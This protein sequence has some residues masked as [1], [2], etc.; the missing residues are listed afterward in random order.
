[1]LASTSTKKAATASVATETTPSPLIR[2]SDATSSDWPA[3]LIGGL[4]LLT[5]A[6]LRG[7]ANG[8]GSPGILAT[9]AG[10]V[11]LLGGFLAIERHSNAPM[12][13]LSLFRQRR[14][15]GAQ[16]VVFGI[17]ASF[18]AVFFYM[19]L[20]LQGVLGLSPIQTGLVYLPGT[21][22][23]F[24]VSALTAQF[25]S[26]VRPAKLAVGGLALVAGGMLSMLLTTTSSSW[27]AILLGE[28]ICCLGTGIFNPAGS[29]LALDA[30]PKHQSGLAAGAN[31]TFRQAGIA[32]GIAALGTLV[33]ADAALGGN[34]AAYVAGFHHI[35]IAATLIATVCATATAALL[36]STP[37]WIRG[38][39]PQTSN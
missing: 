39:A 29:A 15:A 22:L 5:L 18:F 32:I 27:A 13:P 28:L 9:L 19:T 36:L 31:A 10:A 6:L 33:P 1:M 37:A 24:V 12:L 38:V 7:N 4:F 25:A 21:M 35:L 34:P 17:S 11:L 23:M 16:V 20:Y 26:R 14:F 3:T 2:S 30:L 8:W